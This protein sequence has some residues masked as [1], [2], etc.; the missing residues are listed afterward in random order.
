V[1]A[2]YDPAMVDVGDILHGDVLSVTPPGARAMTMSMGGSWAIGARPGALL[3]DVDL[4]RIP[5]ASDNCRLLS[6]AG[7]WDSNKDGFGNRC[8][9]DLDNDGIVTQPD[10]DAV[11]ACKG[12]NLLLLEP[13]AGPEDPP[14]NVNPADLAKKVTCSDADLDAN[15]RVNSIDIGIARRALGKPP[16]PSGKASV[17]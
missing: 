2:E 13:H 8:D 7:Q 17:R 10:V 11:V 9:A 6:N 1:V 16:G 12:A 5:D 3:K 14:I 15:G 4:D